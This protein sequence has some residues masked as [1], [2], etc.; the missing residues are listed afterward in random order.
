MFLTFFRILASRRAAGKLLARPPES[1]G[2]PK[3][4]PDARRR[5]RVL[6]AQHDDLPG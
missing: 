3:R 2:P 4:R 5:F 6:R 1:R